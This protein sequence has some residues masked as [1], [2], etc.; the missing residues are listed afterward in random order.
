MDLFRAGVE[1]DAV[2]LAGELVDYIKEEFDRSWRES[3]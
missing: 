2:K 3:K 1:K